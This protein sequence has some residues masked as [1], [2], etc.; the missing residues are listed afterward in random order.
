MSGTQRNAED[1][2]EPVASFDIRFTRYI[3]NDGKAVGSLPEI[4]KDP[5][6]LI[7]LYRAMVLNRAFDK[8]AIALQRTGKLGTYASSLGQEAVFVAVGSVMKKQDVLVPYYR[9]CGA[10]LLRGVTMTELLL[11]WGG[12]E[13]GMDYAGPREDLPICVPI[14][15]Q[16]PQAAGVALAMKY[17]REPRVAVTMFGDGA[18]SK[19]D[20]YEAAN[21][22][23]VWNL[24]LVFVLINNQWAISVPLHEQTHCET[25]AQKAIAAGFPGEQVDGNDVIA[26]FDRC[27]AAIERARAGGGPTLIEAI[28]YRLSDHTT[29][30]D[31]SRYRSDE[32]LST[33][34][35][36]E[37]IKRLR[38]YLITSG[39]WDQQ[40]DEQLHST[41]ELEVEQAAQAYLDTPLPEPESMFDYLYAN[42]P[43]TLH[44]QREDLS[45]KV[46]EACQS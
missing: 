23:G 13:R 43:A 16:I 25:L 14:A 30:D 21:A 10:Q 27:S 3:D 9:E 34:W 31:A 32:E 28:T 2:R 17:R 26:V 29:A 22:A 42:L 44:P 24:P 20:F 7:P 11:Y 37:P 8:Q 45:K 36:Y 19:G 5:D 1:N 35:E 15:S 41:C 39:Y 6:A 4:A 18:T 38:Q 46:K 33:H 40:R 12:D